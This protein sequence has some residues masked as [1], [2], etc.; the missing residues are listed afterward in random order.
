VTRQNSK[1]RNRIDALKSFNPAEWVALGIMAA[2]AVTGAVLLVGPWVLT[3]V[4]APV[5]TALAGAL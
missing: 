5:L 1:I 4:L 3:N 2:A